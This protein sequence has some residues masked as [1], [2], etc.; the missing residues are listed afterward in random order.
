MY[1][2]QYNIW[3]SAAVGTFSTLASNFSA[4]SSN[5]IEN[6]MLIDHQTEVKVAV[7]LW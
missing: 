1:R 5:V 4:K 3:P 2:V 7:V 6:M